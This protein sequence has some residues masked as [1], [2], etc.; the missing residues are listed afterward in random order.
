MQPYVGMKRRCS[1]ALSLAIVALG[2]CAGAS[3]DDD[4]A[5]ASGTESV[6]RAEQLF[7]ASP[8]KAVSV[9]SSLPG[10]AR[11]TLRANQGSVDILLE[12]AGADARVVTRLAVAYPTTEDGTGGVVFDHDPSVDYDAE[13][14]LKAA[15]KDLGTNGAAQ[16][17][18]LSPMD[19]TTPGTLIQGPSDLGGC[20]TVYFVSAF[21]SLAATRCPIM[22]ASVIAAAKSVGC[23]V[24]AGRQIAKASSY[25]PE[26]CGDI[27]PGYTGGGPSM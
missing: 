27:P 12:G 4:A 13:T 19:L 3:H 15:Q 21:W 24:F 25:I 7:V 10:I 17:A 5:T 1:L 11:W 23:F 8:S 14:V 18:S 26:T 2:G 6:Q 9:S 16:P 22:L 20:A